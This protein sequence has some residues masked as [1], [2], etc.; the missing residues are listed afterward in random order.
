MVVP[1]L[2]NRLV[3]AK[4]EELQQADGPLRT[5]LGRAWNQGVVARQDAV[6][7]AEQNLNAR[8][9]VLQRLSPESLVVQADSQPA[10]AAGTLADDPLAIEA[11]ETRRAVSGQVERDGVRYAEA[12]GAVRAASTS[13]SSPPRSTMRSRP[14]VSCGRAS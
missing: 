1:R 14:C 5:Q 11:A 8:V 10:L 2:E 12:R 3:N 9:V 7:L 6:D 4:I 13:C